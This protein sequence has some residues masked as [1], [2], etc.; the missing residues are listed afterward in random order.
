MSQKTD[1]TIDEAA[2]AEAIKQKAKEAFAAM[3][4]A[5][6]VRKYVEPE[7]VPLEDFTGYRVDNAGNCLGN[8]HVHT[9]PVDTDLVKFIACDLDKCPPVYVPQ[10]KVWVAYQAEAQIAL[11]KVT[12]PRGTVMRCLIAGVALP[13]AWL[14][15]ISILRSIIKSSTGTPGTLPSIPD[16]PAGT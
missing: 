15:Y 11:D 9:Q 4:A 1:Q 3:R 10:E 8:Y 16:F 7:V 14:Q 2:L 6:P 12:G 5:Q 13:E